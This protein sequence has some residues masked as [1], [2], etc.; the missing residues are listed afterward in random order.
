MLEDYV[1]WKRVA[2]CCRTGRRFWAMCKV[3]RLY[4]DVNFYYRYTN[5]TFK[6]NTLD[7]ENESI[8]FSGNM[9]RKL[10]R[11]RDLEEQNYEEL[12]RFYDGDF[13]I[14]AMNFKTI[15][16]FRTYYDDIGLDAMS[17]E[18]V[19]MLYYS[20][21]DQ[22][23]LEINFIN[24]CMVD[25]DGNNYGYKSF[26]LIYILYKNDNMIEFFNQFTADLMFNPIQHMFLMCGGIPRRISIMRH[27]ELREMRGKVL[28][29]SEKRI[30]LDLKKIIKSTVDR[31]F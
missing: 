14:N 16:R 21:V 31:Q 1:D 12:L 27:S 6:E 8:E 5:I 9:R 26:P 29:S 11:F 4:A 10:L 22:V 17:E 23:P 28:S 2:L 18:F 20:T 7:N 13:Y 19:N 24:S 25:S 30:G 3:F 15:S